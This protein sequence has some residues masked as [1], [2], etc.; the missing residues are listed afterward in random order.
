MIYSSYTVLSEYLFL[1]HSP[2]YSEYG[3]TG[4]VYG[5]DSYRKLEPEI[6][7]DITDSGQELPDGAVRYTLAEL[8]ENMAPQNE[9]DKAVIRECIDGLGVYAAMVAQEG[10]NT[11]KTAE[12]RDF[13]SDIVPYWGL[14]YGEG[15]KSLDNFLRA[16]LN[17]PC[18]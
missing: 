9:R 4:I 13:I 17:S 18:K 12:I 6:N 11:S 15:S 8:I 1:R 2:S 16:C 7:R 10:R 5:V 3:I 14:D